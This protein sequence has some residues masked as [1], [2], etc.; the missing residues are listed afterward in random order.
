MKESALEFIKNTQLHKN[1]VFTNWLWSLQTQLCS[2]VIIIQVRFTGR[3]CRPENS[4]STYTS[5][6][7]NQ[8]WHPTKPQTLTRGSWHYCSICCW[9]C[10]HI[11]FICVGATPINKSMRPRI[12]NPWWDH[13]K[14][15]RRMKQEQYYFT[16][17]VVRVVSVWIKITVSFKEVEYLLCK[18]S[19]YKNYP[20][21]NT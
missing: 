2:S 21:F 17:T 13:N 1:K 19:W 15:C 14:M 7:R 9:S 8:G 11:C 4:S 10:P 18:R 20:K 12:P 5:W 16:H 6:D 3:A